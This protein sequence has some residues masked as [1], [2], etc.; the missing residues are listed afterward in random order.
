MAA[1]LIVGFAACD[2]P[3]IEVTGV[4]LNKTTLELNAGDTETLI[5]TVSPHNATHQRVS[6]RSDRSGIATVCENG[7][8]TAISAGTATISASAGFN[9]PAAT[10]T[11]TVSPVT[12]TLNRAAVE[13][14]VNERVTL[15]AI[16]T[17]ANPISQNV[18]WE[19]SDLAV[20]TVDNNGVVTATG[21]GVATI[22]ATTATGAQ[23]ATSI[24]RI[25]TR[26]QLEDAG[27]VSSQSSDVG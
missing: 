9:L 26:E 16:V 13:L 19:S 5:A 18:T 11:V 8:V 20:A 25:F 12:I 7:I 4:T 15:T 23:T 14:L 21:T 10:V 22:T 24:V 6:W 27:V 17:A 3:L 2:D 1:I